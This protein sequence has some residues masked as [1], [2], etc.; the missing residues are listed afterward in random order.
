[1]MKHTQALALLLCAA[2]LATAGGAAQTNTT[3]RQPG[4]VCRV[5]APRAPGADVGALINACDQRLGAGEGTIAVSGGGNIATRV[6]VSPRHTLLFE[7]GTY[8]ASTPGVVLWL[9]DSSALRCRSLG[10]VLQESTA[11]NVSAGIGADGTPVFT[12]AQDFA[13]GNRNGDPSNDI[14]ITGCH[15]RGARPDFNSAYQTVSLGNCRACSATGNFFDQ[16]RTIGLQ[17]GGGSAYGHFARN[18]TFDGNRFRG[19]AS[20]NLA[21]TNGAAIRVTNNRFEAP[22]QP[23]GPGVSVI[24]VEPNWDDVVD[25]VDISRNTIDAA[26][27]AGDAT[28]W[29]T[30]N[31]IVINASNPTKKFAGVVVSDN[32]II[33]GHKTER[34]SRIMYAD[35]LIRTARGVVVRNN[36]MNHGSR[37]ILLDYG[38]SDTLVEG[39]TIENCGSGSTFPITLSNASRNRVVNNVLTADPSDAIWPEVLNAGHRERVIYEEAGSDDNVFSGNTADV[40]VTGRRSRLDSRPGRGGAGRP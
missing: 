36:R 27:S 18:V 4:N 37:C 10:V 1:M 31:G 2:A 5:A 12:I 38:T 14:Q 22:G 40:A 8:T 7:D 21:V 9:K 13:G 34:G 33:A 17:V 30:T 39:N 28:G 19:V 35:I 32:V 16:T 20:Q 25:G 24:D 11:A 3:A 26:D 6:V 29:K 15:F 23:G